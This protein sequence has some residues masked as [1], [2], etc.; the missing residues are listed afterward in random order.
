MSEVQE[1]PIRLIGDTHV[2]IS[3]DMTWPRARGP[4]MGNLAW[5]LRYAQDTVWK[6]QKL[7]CAE[8]IEAY[9]EIIQSKAGHRSRICSALQRAEREAKNAEA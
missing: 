2:K 7:M 4:Y 1:Y 6:S 9:W 8:I 5:R 3:N